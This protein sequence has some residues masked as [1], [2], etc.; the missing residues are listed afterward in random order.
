[1]D[2]STIDVNV[3][4]T[5]TEI[6][7]NEER[8]I[9]NFIR[10]C[11]RHSLGKFLVAPTFDFDTNTN[12][13]NQQV[14]SGHYITHENNT[15]NLEKEN[16]QA[17]QSIY[18]NITP[19][20][21]SENHKQQSFII[22]SDIGNEDSINP[23][24]SSKEPTQ[25]HFLY[26][27]S[28]VK[29][30]FILINQ[31][32]AH[33]RILYEENLRSM[34]GNRRLVQKEL[35]PLNLELNAANAQLMKNLLPKFNNLGFE[36]GEFGHNNFVVH[37]IPAGLPA[38]I[39]AISLIKNILDQYNENQELQ[40]GIDVNIARSYAKCA[41]IKKGHQLSVDEMKTIINDLFACETPFVSPSG[42]KTFIK[43]DL[44]DIQKLF[45]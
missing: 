7:F 14:E 11:V 5:K 20:Q 8:L 40:L 29:N 19:N 43:Q 17:W 39:N 25:I 15:A 32:H 4:P 13:T 42:N 18:Q 33:E 16:L 2:P 38:E 41:S 34:Q 26:I 44:E 3:H 22:E 30:G 24:H 35:F 10:V 31:Q 37:G 27:L 23:Q 28:Q 12:I 36:I 21:P 45:K 9:Y 1:V 6:K